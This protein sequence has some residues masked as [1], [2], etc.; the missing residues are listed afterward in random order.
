MAVKAD[1]QLSLSAVCDDKDLLNSVFKARCGRLKVRVVR[2][3]TM[4]QQ[5][6][7]VIKKKAN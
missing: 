2:M 4:N 6:Q 1:L 7:K 3:N 5:V